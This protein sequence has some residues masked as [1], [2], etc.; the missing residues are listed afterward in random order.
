MCWYH[1][2][3]CRAAH[4]WIS[5]GEVV[6]VDW[7]NG[8]PLFAPPM[9]ALPTDGIHSLGGQSQRARLAAAAVRGLRVYAIGGSVM[10]EVGGC[11][12]RGCGGKGVLGR[13]RNSISGRRADGFV[14][15]LMGHIERRYPG[16]PHSLV[17][18]ARSGN[19]MGWM[20]PCMLSYVP[21][22]ADLLVI[23]FALNDPK[24]DEFWQLL[25]VLQGYPEGGPMLL[26]LN[27]FYWCRVTDGSNAIGHG[28][29]TAK[30]E[31]QRFTLTRKNEAKRWCRDTTLIRSRLQSATH[32]PAAGIEAVMSACGAAVLDIYDELAPRVLSGELNASAITRDGFHPHFGP[33]AKQLLV[34]SWSQLLKRWFDSAMAAP[35]ITATHPEPTAPDASLLRRLSMCVLRGNDKDAGAWGRDFNFA[36]LAANL[37]NQ[38]SQHSCNS[39][40]IVS[41]RA[42]C[43]SIAHAFMEEI[44][45]L[46]VIGWDLLAPNASVYRR[47]NDRE[48]ESG[49][50][51]RRQGAVI[52]LPL[53]T[54]ATRSAVTAARIDLLHSYENTGVAS[55]RCLGSCSC[56][57]TVHDTRWEL[58]KTADAGTTLQI[59]HAVIG[60]QLSPRTSDVPGRFHAKGGWAPCIV[61]LR[62][63]SEERVKL[64][65]LVVYYAGRTF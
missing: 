24:E 5:L 57:E 44:P 59:T 15:T 30:R 36:N 21:A 65:G 16:Q 41:G 26:V 23:D 1:K 48:R 38:G 40:A 61:E 32:C 12:G 47:E 56:N 49:Y 8:S 14:A 3:K 62:S 25:K 13:Y 9:L 64:D 42:R 63:E 55:M 18:H 46:R 34:Q 37:A 2:G 28:V 20:L 53:T 51:S 17:N 50:V 7:R 60:E 54:P 10:R 22:N 27:N 6:F 29:R 11:F 39:G 45:T 58:P 19:G 43:F 33:V 4:R 35:M 52:H 31:R